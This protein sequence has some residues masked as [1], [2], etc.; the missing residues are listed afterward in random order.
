MPLTTPDLPPAPAATRA[1]TDPRCTEYPVAD[2][3][4]FFNGGAGDANTG[5]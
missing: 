3:T 2:L 1:W 4:G 5:S